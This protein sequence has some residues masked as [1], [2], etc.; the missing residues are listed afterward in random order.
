M[1]CLCVRERARQCGWF[2]AGSYVA[3][4]AAAGETVWLPHKNGR[5]FPSYC[6][7]FLVCCAPS[8]NCMD[9]WVTER[10]RE[11]FLPSPNGFAEGKKLRALGVFFSLLYCVMLGL[12]T[13][14]CFCVLQG[15]R[16]PRA[17]K[18]KPMFY[19]PRYRFNQSCQC[20]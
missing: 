6:A 5:A 11:L 2:Y 16:A 4:C 13:F 14:A 10:P 12:G 9:A 18:S 7:F 8:V 1:C 19:T 17:C 20:Q 15:S 3:L